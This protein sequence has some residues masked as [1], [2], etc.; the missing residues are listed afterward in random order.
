MLIRAA[1][2]GGV[3]S[4]VPGSLSQYRTSLGTK[5][6]PLLSSRS[7]LPQA[8]TSEE[9]YVVAAELQRFRSE[10]STSLATPIRRRYRKCVSR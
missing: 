7:I 5:T 3:T 6:R 9:F 8:V 1:A 4:R 10:S 2:A